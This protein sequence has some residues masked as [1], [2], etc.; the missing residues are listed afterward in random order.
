[1]ASTFERYQFFCFRFS[2]VLLKWNSFAELDLLTGSGQG[3][4][5]LA[6]FYLKAEVKS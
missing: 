1:M 4:T 5:P 3:V 2:E 6:D